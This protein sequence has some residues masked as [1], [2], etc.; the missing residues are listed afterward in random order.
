M[1]SA[2]PSKPGFVA[3]LCRAIGSDVPARAGAPGRLQL[4]FEG[5]REGVEAASARAL[6]IC[7]QHGGALLPEAEA[8]GFWDERHVVA[9]QI[10]ARQI[11][12]IDE[13]NS[14]LPQG[15]QFAFLHVAQPPSAVLEYKRRCELLL[16][17]LEGRARAAELPAREAVVERCLEARPRG[18][19]GAPHDPLG[20]SSRHERGPRRAGP[21]VRPASAGSRPMGP[22]NSWKAT[23][24]CATKSRARWH[25]S[26]LGT[27][28]RF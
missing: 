22:T 13:R 18:S 8:Q 21:S 28:A 6:A 7:R 24:T 16:L 19:G 12:T 2:T 15:I 3:T 14:R 26:I 5:F 25:G 17:E 1:V 27:R 20:P 23:A 11:A 10:R 9:E 4:A